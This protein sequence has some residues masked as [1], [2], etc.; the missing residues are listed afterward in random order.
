MGAYYSGKDAAIT[1]DLG[2]GATAYPVKDWTYRESDEVVKMRAGGDRGTSRD[3]LGTDWSFEGTMVVRK[4]GTPIAL[5]S[6][7]GA[8]I[9]F[10]GK[11]DGATNPKVKIE[12]TGMCTG[13][14]VVADTSKE[15]EI[16][17]KLECSSADAA[18]LPTITP[19]V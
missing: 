11:T 8:E 4:D 16:K 17:I 3:Y 14:D 15:L 9:D 6:M 5:G 13:R 7:R 1:L 2:G 12:G 18:D 19:H 10:V